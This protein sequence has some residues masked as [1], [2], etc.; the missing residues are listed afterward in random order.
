MDSMTSHSKKKNIVLT[1]WAWSIALYIII[2]FLGYVA[3]NNGLVDIS[4]KNYF[5]VICFLAA[6]QAFIYWAIRSGYYE[7]W[8][9]AT[10]LYYE[11]MVPFLVLIYFLFLVQDFARPTVVNISLLGALFGIFA[12]KRIH[13]IMLAGIIILAFGITTIVD[14]A[15]GALTLN[16]KTIIFQWVITVLIIVFFSFVGDYVSAMRSRLREHRKILLQ[17]NEELIIAHRELKSALRQMSEK[18]VHDELTGLYNRHQFSETLYAQIAVAK[19]TGCPLGLL[20]IDVDHFKQVNDTYGHLAGDKILKA[21]NRI[22][23]NCLRKADF[24]A[25]YGGEEFVVLLPNTDLKTLKEVAE[26]I[27]TFIEALAFDDIAPG[28][29]V[30][31]SIGGTHF[32]SHEKADQMI[33]RADQALYQAKNKGRNLLVYNI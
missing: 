25:R 13:F 14:F 30:T 12:L 17:R 32:R 28:F 19:G 6:F 22:P 29:G 9:E 4:T 31:I 3:I 11:I 2:L 27:R 5:V 18:A 33:E 10:F 8:D 16:P 26:R 21:F 1:R 24:I 23:E 7:R 15:K 20:I